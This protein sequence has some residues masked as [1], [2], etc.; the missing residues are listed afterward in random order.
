MARRIAPGL[1]QATDRVRGFGLLVVGLDLAS[2]APGR[3]ERDEWFQRFERLWVLATEDT[4]VH[5]KEPDRWPGTRRAQRMLAT[6]D[7]LDLTRPILAQQL[8]SGLWGTYRR[9]AEHYRLIQPADATGRRS[10]RPR[11][12]R[13]TTAGRRLRTETLSHIRTG[14]P[15]LGHWLK[16]GRVERH[17][18]R[19]WLRPRAG[20]TASEASLLSALIGAVDAE[21]G[22][23]LRRLRAEFDRSGRLTLHSLRTGSLTPD[24]AAALE[25]GR[26]VLALMRDVEQP[27]RSWTA[28]GPR[29]S[30]RSLRRVLARPEWDIVI[31]ANEADL[32]HLWEAL[33]HDPSVEAVLGHHRWLSDLRGA[34]PWTRPD[35]SKERFVEP[36]F[37][38]DAPRHLFSEGLRFRE[39]RS[40]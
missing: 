8:S 5:G 39:G 11:A 38:L 3:R 33:N 4:R 15:R 31:A 9:A 14:E 6:D 37:G 10:T 29:P 25:L 30:R 1:T 7:D 35:R 22:G 12:Y 23:P 19:S 26:A 28:G 36:D 40:G 24:Q 18:P 17:G 27:F 2:G 32:A 20:C 34:E 16:V 13:L 21:A